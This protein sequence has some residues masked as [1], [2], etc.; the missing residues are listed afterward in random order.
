MRPRREADPALADAFARRE[1]QAEQQ[2]N[3][4][5]IGLIAAASATDLAYAW[6]DHRLDARL[7][8][9]AALLVGTFSIYAALVHLLNR[10]GVH[11]PW[12]KYVTI[13]ADYGFTLL[14]ISEYRRIGFFVNEAP[15]GGAP[16]FIGFLMLL[17][18]LNAFRQSRG[19]LVYSTALAT[20][21]GCSLAATSSPRVE[22]LFY[23][24]MV[25]VGS[26]V[27]AYYLSAGLT[28]MF[29]RLRRREW[30]AR[31]LPQRVV[32][33][34]E[35][36]TL[37]VEPGGAQRRTTL[38]LADIRGF[39]ALAERRDPSQVVGLLNE[40]F[41]AM[42]AVIWR[43]G[44]MVDKFI[45]DAVLAVFGAPVPQPDHARR[46][47][48]A[49]RAMQTCLKTLNQDW[50]RRG[51]PSLRIGIALHSGTVVA[52]FV[53]ATERLEY[54]VI[55]DPVN[56]TARIE[57]LNKVYGTDVLLSEST[58][59]EVGADIGVEFLADVPLRG[60]EQRVRVY[61]LSPAPA[62]PQGIAGGSAAT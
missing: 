46:A 19:A 22:L 1:V 8:A 28:A 58:A 61:R 36:G 52:G 14:V 3:R 32:Q 47:V 24:P 42:S 38:L 50:V 31:F 23:T 12:L 26:G 35:A 10:G 40:H 9:T 55:G 57:E 20:A 51:L 30:L 54:T 41:A 18:V 4:L 44:G 34:I 48:E 56:V 29:L 43:H 21:I 39:T 49:A 37:Q 17:N 27:V 6:W 16:E 2:I 60:R 5:R 7:A 53:G 45:G 25:L 13:A 15:E 59:G 11:R 33:A 62:R